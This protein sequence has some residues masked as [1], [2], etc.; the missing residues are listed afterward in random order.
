ME[1]GKILGSKKMT[2]GPKGEGQNVLFITQLYYMI[3][4]GTNYKTTMCLKQNQL[5]VCP[6]E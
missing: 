6:R 3:V 4:L 2:G 5:V 1:M